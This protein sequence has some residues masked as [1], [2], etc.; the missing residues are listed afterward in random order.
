M[1]PVTYGV[2]ITCITQ[3]PKKSYELKHCCYR[4][5]HSVQFMVSL[6]QSSQSCWRQQEIM[7]SMSVVRWF[8]NLVMV[9]FYSHAELLTWEHSP[10][11]GFRLVSL[12]TITVNMW[13]VRLIVS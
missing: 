4:D 9:E 6:H 2:H 3:I 11:S 7:E 12:C 13:H 1:F 8:L 10:V 5:L